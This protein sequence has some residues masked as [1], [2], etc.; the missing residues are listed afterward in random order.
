MRSNIINFL[1]ELLK[2]GL[3]DLVCPFDYSLAGRPDTGVSALGLILGLRRRCAGVR[4]NGEQWLDYV[5][6]GNLMLSEGM[7]IM[8]WSPVCH[9]TSRLPRVYEKFQTAYGDSGRKWKKES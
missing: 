1:A 5:K 7:R 4:S 2:H 3:Q 9:G 6:V 8:A